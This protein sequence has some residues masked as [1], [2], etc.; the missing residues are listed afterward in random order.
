MEKALLIPPHMP[1]ITLVT[2]EKGHTKEFLASVHRSRKLHRPWAYPP[3]TVSQFR[4]YLASLRT[5]ARIGHFVLTDQ[6][7]IAAFINIG[8]IIRGPFRNG[9]LGYSAL[10]PHEGKGYVSAGLRKVI[11]R[12]FRIHRL[13]RLEANIQPG[14][15]RSAELVQ[16]LG[17]V[18]EGFSRKY[19]NVGGHWA[20]HERYAITA[21]LWPPA[22]SR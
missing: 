9:L 22:K 1:T 18:H 14:N 5:G 6:G 4:D 21:D 15:L 11:S 20:D 3:S 2:P 13:H 12:A 19:L 16:R 8:G 7:E 17:F 10:V